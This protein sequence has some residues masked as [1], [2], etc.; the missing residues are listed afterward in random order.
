M[1]PGCM[2]WVKLRDNADEKSSLNFEP[3]TLT[4]NPCNPSATPDVFGIIITKHLPCPVHLTCFALGS[5][6]LPLIIDTVCRLSF[7]HPSDRP[8][9]S[10]TDWAKFQAYLEDEILINPDLHNR[11][12]NHTCIEKMFGAVMKALPASTPERC[13]HDDPLSR[14][15]PVFRTRYAYRMAVDAVASHQGSC[16][17]I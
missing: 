12:A 3:E 13:P 9:F 16:S 4:T 8:D 17:K 14:Y 10:R 5:N 15:L 1:L 11:V 2:R 6:H 7:L